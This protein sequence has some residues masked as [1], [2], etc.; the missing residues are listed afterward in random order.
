MA[1]AHF[2][3]SI[4]S[5]GNGSSAVLSAAYRH[6]ARMDFEREARTVDY[7]RKLGL[8]HEEFVIPEDAPDWLRSMIAD[9]SVAGAAEAF[10]NRVEAFEKRE[11]AQ[12]AKDINF[13]LPL[14]LT[15][16]QRTRLDSAR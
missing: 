15:A 13:A 2:S 11:D 14:E 9:R 8:L 4:V 1:I 6:C 3:A 7:S 12:L 10:W 16:E 5:R